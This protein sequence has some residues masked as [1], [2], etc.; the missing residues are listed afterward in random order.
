MGIAIFVGSRMRRWMNWLGANMGMM[1]RYLE[2]VAEE[3]GRD[4]IMDPEVLAEAQRRLGLA[5]VDNPV[6]E[7]GQVKFLQ[8]RD[9]S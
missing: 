8:Q 7:D 9:V 1:K 6:I 2:D 3:L 5:M 4:D